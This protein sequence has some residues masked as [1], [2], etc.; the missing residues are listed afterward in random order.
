[1]R[2]AL[3]EKEGQEH[4]KLQETLSSQKINNEPGIVIH[5]FINPIFKGRSSKDLQTYSE[6][7]PQNKQDQV[8]ID[9]YVYY[10]ADCANLHTYIY[11][12]L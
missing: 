6:T 12:Q 2:P 9:K 10:Q 4:P 3:A 8:E 11:T 7:L 5:D 1:M